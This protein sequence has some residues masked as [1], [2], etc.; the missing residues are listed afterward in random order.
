MDENILPFPVPHRGDPEPRRTAL[1]S[2]GFHWSGDVWR[3]GRVALSDGDIDAMDERAW[4][5]RL[6]RW[7]TRRPKRREQ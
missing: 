6:K 1:A 5:Q 2:I 4:Q 7:T 3:R